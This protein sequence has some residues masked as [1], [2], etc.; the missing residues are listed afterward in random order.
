MQ[1][2][3]DGEASQDR[4][5]DE[6]RVTKKF[7]PHHSQRASLAVVKGEGEIVD[8]TRSRAA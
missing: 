1:A 2:G 5:E 7:V 8:G 3:E 4:T 6:G